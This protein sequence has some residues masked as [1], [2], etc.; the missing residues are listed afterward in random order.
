L[1]LD[2]DRGQSFDI[3][4]LDAASQRQHRQNTECMNQLRF[5]WKDVTKVVTNKE[6]SKTLLNSVSGHVSAT[7]CLAIMGP[8]GSGKTT[9][10]DV[11]SNRSMNWT[12]EILVNG[13]KQSET[14]F[15]SLMGYVPQDDHM[16]G[17][18][19]VR[20]SLLY[21]SMLA[22]AGDRWTPQKRLEKT[23]SVLRQLDLL[24]CADVYVGTVF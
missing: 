24:V 16:E 18:L 8:S 5:A 13:K 6:I 10:L 22:M 17:S 19:T 23:D 9:L 14:P 12:G 7:Q 21:V 2:D 11:L 15:R 1:G 20:E 4:Q 3:N